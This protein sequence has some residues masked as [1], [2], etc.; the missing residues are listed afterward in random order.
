MQDTPAASTRNLTLAQKASLTSGADFWHLQGI[1]D[2]GIPSV[3]V[4]DGPHG[5]RKQPA[6]ADPVGLG[7]SLPATCFPPAVALAS[8][9]DVDLIRRVGEALGAET[10][11]GNVAVL[12]G[13]GVNIKRT[14]LCG[15]NFEYFSEDPFLS[16]RF[17]AAWV[18]GV[19]SQG[20]GASL[21][22]FAANNQ[23]TDRFRVSA[24][25]DERTL[26]EIY[27]PAFEHVVTHAKPLTV[28]CSY[29][30]VNGT[31]ASENQWLLG[32]VLRGEW[33]F[34]GLVV[35]DWG[36]VADRVEALA[37]GLDIE[38]PPTRSDQ[39]IVDAVADGR[40]TEE[41]VDTAARR[42]LA[43]LDATA[44]AR[45]DGGVYD[46]DAHHE[47]AR[48]AALAGAVLL[49]NDGAMLP[50]DPDGNE[51]IAVIGEFAR[52]PR[53]QGAGSSQVVP[54]RVDNALDAITALAGADRVVFA[55]GFTLDGAADPGLV[56]E[57][58]RAVS[59]ADVAVVFLGLPPTAE[60]EGYDRAHI[61]LPA[62]Q[63]ALLE[64]VHAANPE[65]V[66]VLSNGSAVATAPWQHRARALLEGWLLGQAGGTATADLL[67]GAAEPSGRLTETIPLRLQDT[68]AYLQFPGSEQHVRYSEGIYVGYRY[69]D[70]L[71][72]PV[73]YP[74]GHGL[75][76]TTFE[77]DGLA[78]TPVRANAFDVAVTVTNTGV[79]AGAQTVQVYVHD[80]ESSV[81]RPVQELKGFAKAFLAPGESR[82]LTVTLDERAFAFWSTAE[83]RWKIEAGHAEIRVGFSSRD[84]RARQDVGLPGD[85]IPG[86]LDGMS[87]LAEWLAHP[88]GAGIIRPLLDEGIKAMDTDRDVVSLIG[89]MP[90]AKIA[91]FGVAFD[92]HAVDALVEEYLKAA[93]A[94]TASA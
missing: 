18:H 80:A 29:N 41:Q 12:L 42:V 43:L 31:Y 7:T 65:T 40:L 94:A 61:D 47:L 33:G 66:V 5:L 32:E 77:I 15:R 78:V 49:K 83:R 89:G 86:P 36:A 75:S 13:P 92:T 35:S 57:A 50:L 38:M 28:M 93:E 9:W 3:M 64:A 69:Y 76:Y 37:A 63:L 4:A 71:D 2:A 67:F 11:A 68:P 8:S 34:E 52:T 24:D 44:Q 19:Q 55:P 51:H 72:A 74:F 6:D 48:T 14:P 85:E 62:D 81:D 10:R 58:V 26:R 87:S 1:E 22:H 70:T 53:F 17:G 45:N 27:L 54:H 30:K 79:R 60:S 23:E 46:A 88:I 59:A 39:R 20:V 21:K 25:V 56:A 84:I 82:T 90:L 16:G 91:A 73:A